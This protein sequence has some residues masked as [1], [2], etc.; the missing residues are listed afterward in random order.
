VTRRH[1]SSL[2]PIALLSACTLEMACPS[3]SMGQAVRRQTAEFSPTGLAQINAVLTDGTPV[4]IAVQ[5]TTFTSDSFP[6]TTSYRKFLWTGWGTIMDH[7]GSVVTAV[8][9]RVGQQDMWVSMSAFSDLGDPRLIIFQD[10]SIEYEDA[11]HHLLEKTAFRLIVFGGQTATA[12][13]AD[14]QFSADTLER[15]AVWLV[16]FPT[17]SKE[18]TIYGIRPPEP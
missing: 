5:R 17:E 3:L 2:F 6:Y 7:P 8:N 9:V 13:I 12:Y 4:E 11:G 15:R 16:E 1:V 18:E 14:L 10:I